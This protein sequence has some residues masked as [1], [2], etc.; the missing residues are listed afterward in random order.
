MKKILPHMAASPH[1]TPEKYN[2]N[3]LIN[4]PFPSSSASAC[5]RKFS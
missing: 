4:N 2:L 1:A 5:L 3:E